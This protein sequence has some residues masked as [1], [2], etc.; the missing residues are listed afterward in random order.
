MRSLFTLACMVL[1]GCGG[2]VA[3]DGIASDAAGEDTAADI[4]SP[5]DS[6]TTPDTE[7]DSGWVDSGT[8]AAPPDP[9]NLADG[10]PLCGASCTHSCKGFA[11]CQ[12]YSTIGGATS[13]VA[14][15]SEDQPLV[16]GEASPCRV[17]DGDSM[18][19]ARYGAGDYG[20]LRCVQRALCDRLA[21]ELKPACWFQDKTPWDPARTVPSAACP[22]NGK[23]LGMCGGSCGGCS[24][25]LF[26]TGRSPDHPFGVCASTKK[27]S[28]AK[29]LCGGPYDGPCGASEACLSFKA[30]AGGDQTLADRYGFCIPRDRCKQLQTSLPGGIFCK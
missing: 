12:P 25:G 14:M 9:C 21:T 29:N 24:D 28:G 4:G 27:A 5:L 2:R 1:A 6:G 23:L 26:C 30:G 20:E 18:L 11:G 3:D 7:I 22:S 16:G 13:T 19:C 10:T 15:C 8:D 17:C